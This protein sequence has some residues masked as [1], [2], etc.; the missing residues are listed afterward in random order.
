M[1]RSGLPIRLGQAAALPCQTCMQPCLLPNAA[2]SAPAHLARAAQVLEQEAADGVVARALRA[3]AAV[4][5][6]VV[7][8]FGGVDRDA[9]VLKG[10]AGLQVGQQR[11]G[12]HRIL[13]AVAPLDGPPDQVKGLVPAAHPTRGQDAE[14]GRVP[15]QLPLSRR[16]GQS[17]PA[18]RL[19]LAL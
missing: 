5:A 15:G 2:S 16:C 7:G 3:V 10:V 4:G 8:A 6:V 13:L 9:P 17:P 11:L 12:Q 1:E 18:M 14:A 19:C